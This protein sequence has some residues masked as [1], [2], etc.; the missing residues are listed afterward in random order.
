MTVKKKPNPAAS[1]ANA[2]TEALPSNNNKN[3]NEDHGE[4]L[5]V[6]DLA[7]GGLEVDLHDLGI[8]ADDI[9]AMK[10]I[11]ACLAERLHQAQQAQAGTS[12]APA[13]A[14]AKGKGHQ[15][16]PEEIEDQLNK[17]KEQELCCKAM[18]Q[19]IQDCLV[20]MQ[21][22]RQDPGQCNRH[23][24]LKGFANNLFSSKENS[25]RT[26]RKAST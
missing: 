19:A 10:R 9:Q 11:D 21:P 23:L 13:A 18:R 4:D 20:M 16:T 6:E 1:E 14:G 12:N 3:N 26:K 7:D 2:S 22:L 17:L 15:L 24:S 25:S 8:S 5:E